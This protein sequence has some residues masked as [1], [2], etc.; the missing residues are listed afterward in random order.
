MITNLHESLA[1]KKSK[2]NVSEYTILEARE[3]LIAINT[4]RHAN[5]NSDLLF[6]EYNNL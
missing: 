5:K 3:H 6:T 2:L 1:A 4:T